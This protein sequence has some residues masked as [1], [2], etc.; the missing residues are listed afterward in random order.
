MKQNIVPYNSLLSNL[1]NEIES[2][3]NESYK[4]ELIYLENIS[5]KYDDIIKEKLGNN[6]LIASYN[7]F[8]NK[9]D[10][11]LPE[12]L[13]KIKEQWK[14]AYEEVYNDINSNKD[15]FKSSVFEFFYLG[16]FYQ[17]TYAQNISYGFG[18]SVMEKLKNDFNYTNK[19]YYNLIA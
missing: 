4:P 15:N 8:K 16:N 5:Q 2:K 1:D 13:N 10:D 3:K 18:E 11:I 7:Y 12:E 17:Q 6:L 9:S 19:Y 14:N